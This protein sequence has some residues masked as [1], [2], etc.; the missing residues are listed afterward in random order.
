MRDIFDIKNKTVCVMGATG[1]IGLKLVDAFYERGAVVFAGSRSAAK[2]KVSKKGLRYIYADITSS[3]SVADFI[4]VVEKAGRRIDVWIN[5]ALPRVGGSAGAFEIIDTSLIEKEASGHLIGFYRCC[6]QAFK[7]MKKNRRGNIINFG[8]IYGDI[9]PDFRIYKNT[10]ITKSPAY[11][12]IE[13]GINTLTKYLACYGAKYNIRVN[14]LCPGGVLD[15]HSRRFQKQYSNRVPMSRMARP[16]ELVGPAVFL[17][18]DASSYI[19]GHL[20]Y[21]DGGLRAW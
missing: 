9:S 7:H 15:K 14:A 10:E 8:S 18:S 11:P 19:T 5:C 21:V 20:L 17:A 3:E 1:L 4:R 6:Q 13:G 2:K 16:E 12:L